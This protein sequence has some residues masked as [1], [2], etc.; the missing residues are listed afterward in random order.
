MY[1]IYYHKYN[2]LRYYYN[3]L[4]YLETLIYLKIYKKK[5]LFLRKR[6]TSEDI[7]MCWQV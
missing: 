7:R 6:L 4:G 2:T 1:V 5:C 3:Q